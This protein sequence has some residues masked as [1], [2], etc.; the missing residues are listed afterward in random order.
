MTLSNKQITVIFKALC[1]ENRVQIFR[2]LQHGEKCA[3]KLLEAMQFTQPTLSH[4]M[5]ILCDSGLVVGRKEG[6]WMYYSVSQ[7]GTQLAVKALRELTKV[8]GSDEGCCK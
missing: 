3:C 6:K 1:D 8:S 7:E 5:K 4:H 2:L